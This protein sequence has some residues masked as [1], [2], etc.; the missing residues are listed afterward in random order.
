MTPP[1]EPSTPQ[2]F[3]SNAEFLTAAFA[4]LAAK[5]SRMATERRLRQ[6]LDDPGGWSTTIV[7]EV[8]SVANQEGA[9][10]LLGLRDREQILKEDLDAR[11]TLHRQDNSREPL[12]IDLLCEDGGLGPEER[13]TLLLCCL[14]AVSARLAEQTLEVGR[15][16]NSL[17][18]DYLIEITEPDSLDARFRA[19]R[20]FLPTSKLLQEGLI[21]VGYPGQYASPED[22]LG[23]AVQVTSKTFAAIT[24]E[25]GEPAVADE[26]VPQ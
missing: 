25:P 12:G 9:R 16:F 13:L 19:R 6:D 4:W 10:R 20:Q 17:T 8:E 26:E 1:S 18:V 24:G 2:P 7:G 11:L 23:S 3:S 5:I 14:P 15:F 21:T 22:L